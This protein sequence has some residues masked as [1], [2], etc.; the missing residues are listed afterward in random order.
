MTKSGCK[1]RVIKLTF[2]LFHFLDCFKSFRLAVLEVT[3]VIDE[4]QRFQGSYWKRS[5]KF[6]KI[7]LD[8]NVGHAL[9]S[10]FTRYFRN[11]LPI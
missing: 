5:S 9:T 3:D 8:G 6:C 10:D 4:V 2:V 11:I 1:I 7:S